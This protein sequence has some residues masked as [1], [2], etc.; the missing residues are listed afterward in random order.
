[1]EWAIFR[2]PC[3]RDPTRNQ[4]LTQHSATGLRDDCGHFSAGAPVGAASLDTDCS[5]LARAASAPI[6]AF[7]ADHQQVVEKTG[8]EYEHVELKCVCNSCAAN[9][10][11]P[12]FLIATVSHRP[13]GRSASTPL[14]RHMEAV[15]QKRSPTVSAPRMAVPSVPT[16]KRKRAPGGALDDGWSGVQ[17]MKINSLVRRSTCA[18][19]SHASIGRCSVAEGPLKSLRAFQVVRPSAPAVVEAVVCI[20]NC[21]DQLK[22]S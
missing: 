12:D 11:P 22:K 7:N 4:Y 19:R 6:T 9:L 15:L 2:P 3:G 21:G 1:M 13:A 14:D 18:K 10:R 17:L 16:G 8:C 20:R 5:P